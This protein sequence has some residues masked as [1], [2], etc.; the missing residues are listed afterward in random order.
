[1]FLWNQWLKHYVENHHFSSVWDK[2]MMFPLFHWQALGSIHLNH[3]EPPI[4]V[5]HLLTPGSHVIAHH[6]PRN[7]H[8]LEYYYVIYIY[9]RHYYSLLTLSP[10]Q[11]PPIALHA[12]A[13]LNWHNKKGTTESYHA[14]LQT[15][16]IWF[17]CSLLW[18]M[19][20]LPDRLPAVPACH[21]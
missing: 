15:C 5:T 8:S 7:R 19:R 10:I 9:I 18:P 14:T 2:R 4:S 11:I 1:M 3:S 20:K 12:L 21:C 13:F 6:K 17:S 16:F